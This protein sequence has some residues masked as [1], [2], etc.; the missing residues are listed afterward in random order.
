MI[1]DDVIAGGDDVL[2]ASPITDGGT[3]AH[4]PDYM[5]ANGYLLSPDGW[6]LLAP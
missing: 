2:L 4:E 1:L 5:F 3:C 6:K